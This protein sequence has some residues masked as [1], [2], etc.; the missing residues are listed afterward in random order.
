MENTAVTVKGPR[1]PIE[2]HPCFNEKARHESSRIHLP[3]APRCNMQCNF[4][5][6][7]FNCVNESRPG[8]TSTI[9]TPQQALTYVH[10]QVERLKGLSVVGIAGPG[11]PF[12]NPEE[13]LST[14]RLVREAYPGM[15]L[16]VATNGL[17]LLP[18]VQ[19]LAD[20]EVSHVTLTINAVDPDIGASIY[21]WMRYEKRTHTGA[22]AA[23]WL[24]NQQKQAI[25]E[26]AARGVLVKVNSICIPGINEDHIETVAKE[27]AALGASILNVMALKPAKGTP[28]EAFE[29]P[30][31]TTLGRIRLKARQYVPQMSHCSR[32]R[33]DAAGLVG[34]EMK[35]E[36]MALLLEIA[37]K[38][39]DP[40][41]DHE[42]HGTAPQGLVAVATMEG[43]LVNQHLGE[44]DKLMI[45]RPGAQRHELVDIRDTPSPGAGNSRWEALA[46]Q[47]SDCATL[48]VSGVGPGPR[49]VLEGKGIKI[50]VVE[51]LITEALNKLGSGAGL[52]CMHKQA[53]FKCGSSCSGTG[54]GCG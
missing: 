10:R 13:T 9:L 21:G 37:R 8:I 48:L 47:L 30:A 18:H 23:A 35:M 31:A 41:A 12:A 39:P 33:A 14:L 24:W 22:E 2:N 26:L 50:E 43:M 38:Q 54:G 15:L 45:Y 51:G 32:C 44:A 1:L 6:R 46:D 7:D 17:G 11:D 5:N 20:L 49:S 19:A 3:V 16:C 25:V 29:E 52:S 34:E 40:T 36:D 53:A 42:A 28:F 4:C 27:V